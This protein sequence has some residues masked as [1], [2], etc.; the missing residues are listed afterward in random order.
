[1]SVSNVMDEKIEFIANGLS[2]EGMISRGTGTKGVVITHPH[3]QY[4]GDMYNPVVESIG[5]VY[6]QKGLTTLRFN[7]RGVGRSEGSYGNGIDE[8]EDV[9]AAVACLKELKAILSK[10][11]M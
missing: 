5:H 3:P 11:I 9:L 10:N 2:I 7:F 4:G 8:Q 6:Q 1:M